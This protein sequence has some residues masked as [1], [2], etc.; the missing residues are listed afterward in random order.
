VRLLNIQ[1]KSIQ[2]DLY[3]NQGGHQRLKTDQ[4]KKIRLESNIEDLKRELWDFEGQLRK[5][6]FQKSGARE[7]A[8]SDLKALREELARAETDLLEMKRS[9]RRRK[10]QKRR[11]GWHEHLCRHWRAIFVIILVILAV[12]DIAIFRIVFGTLLGW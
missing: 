6:D 11:V 7:V 10:W 8:E 9:V 12:G 5:S 1:L 4:E 3:F 2:T